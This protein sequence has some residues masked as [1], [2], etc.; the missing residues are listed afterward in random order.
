MNWK[1]F[2]KHS[3]ILFGITILFGI[4]YF[5]ITKILR[6]LKYVNFLWIPAIITI[7]LIPLFYSFFIKKS[8]KELAIIAILF[9]LISSVVS[10]P[11]M[12]IMKNSVKES[13]GDA[14]IA[15]LLLEVFSINSVTLIDS[16]IC[17]PYSAKAINSG[18]DEKVE[19]CPL[20]KFGFFVELIIVNIIAFIII[21]LSMITGSYLSKFK[22]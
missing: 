2:F 6:Q 13:K 16:P 14:P 15:I 11:I 8:T 20:Q 12:S 22:K 4:I 5:L 7:M 1:D 18:P 17:A 19:V 9:I 10:L 3:L 21:L